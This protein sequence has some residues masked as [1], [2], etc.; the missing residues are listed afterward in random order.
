[1]GMI[2][3]CYHTH[4]Y[5]CG[6]AK[7]TEEEYVL[8]AIK[9]GLKV[10]G[11]SDHVLL[12]GVD[13]RCQRGSFDELDDYINTVNRLKEKYKDQIEIHLGFECECSKV[14]E[15]YYRSLLKDKGVEYLIIGQH[16]F[17]HED[18]SYT[19]IFEYGNAD[20]TLTKYV[21]EVIEGMKTGLFTYLAHPDLFIRKY[22]EIN[23]HFKRESRRLCEACVK[24]DI[25]MEINLGGVRQKPFL[26]PE[27]LN[28]PSDE[29]FKIA[30]EYPIKMIVGV[31]AHNPDDFMDGVSDYQFAEDLINRFKLNH[32][33]RLEFKKID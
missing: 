24:Y 13:Q 25:P 4:T 16:L 6:H 3:Y 11:F 5:R 8:S 1:M 22:K 27:Y 2:D 26:K 17:F 19:W 12:P 18:K 28:Y 23:E 29:F 7:G 20:E 10:V 32:I 31:D 15:D 30:S 33:T 9:N 21:D 14:F